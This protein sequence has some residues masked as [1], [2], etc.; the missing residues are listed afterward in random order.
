MKSAFIL[1]A[2]AAIAADAPAPAKGELAKRRPDFGVILNDDGDL[3]FVDPDPKLAERLL[4]ANIEAHAALGI[5]TLV[6]CI[7]SGSDTLN[8][9][10][11]VASPIGWRKTKVERE[12]KS[13]LPRME[14][15]RAAIAANLDA[16]RIAGEESHRNGLRF[17]PSL[18]MN[19]SHFIFD[20]LNYPLTGEFWMK[21]HERLSI[22]DSPV[23]FRKG[24]EN[25][26]DYRHK[27]VRDFRLAIIDEVIARNADVIDGFELDFNRVQVF[28]PKGKAED[29]APLMRELV[30]DVRRRLD[31]VERQTGRPMSL[32][33]R[34]P[35]SLESCR[36]AGL[37]VEKWIEEGLVDL[38]SPAQLMTLA[39]DM[40][41]RDL[42]AK[43]HSH[44]VR[45]YPSLYPRTSWRAPLKLD[46]PDFGL[47]TPVN[48]AATKAEV[49]GAAANY[50]NMGA[51]G[52]YL[53]NYYGMETG[54]RPHPDS[55]HGLL[56]ALRHN[57]PDASPKTFAVTKTYY[58]DNVE[59]SYAY[60]KQLPAV[61]DGER[62]FSIEV[63]ELPGDSPFPLESCV[64]R[65][66]LKD[67]T[68]NPAP[69]LA[70]NGR[71]LQPL[72]TVAV[73]PR[74][75]P[76]PPDAATRTVVYQISDPAILKRGTNLLTVRGGK[77]PVTDL[78]IS[79]SHRNKLS[80]L[81]F[82]AYDEARLPSD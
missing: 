1:L 65:L 6:Y 50:R 71:A 35:P 31:A 13:W 66:G 27:E 9:P 48:C 25:L 75:K 43:A 14:N 21:N 12:V 11:K 8:Y 69:E 60:V 62:K 61:V 16:V 38:V 5:G 52:F 67:D 58:H 3:S 10:T 79:F 15:A 32:F 77:L 53:F 44:G 70:L 63:G 45:V 4:R 78:E 28:F 57:K 68:N 80:R 41:I 47:D 56:A 51:D 22:G 49:L 55:M 40:P 64:L 24:Y 18:R 74:K 54:E 20:P 19:D 72:K 42:I 82:R 34:I 30:R 39:H 46:L 59:P 26:F 17:L 81:L 7:G 29:G 37:E 76:L 33:V 73:A 23:S 2:A 36:W